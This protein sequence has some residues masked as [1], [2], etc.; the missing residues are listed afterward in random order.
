MDAHGIV[1]KQQTVVLNQSGVDRSM[2]VLHQ[3][4]EISLLGSYILNKT[5]HRIGGPSL[6]YI[7]IILGVLG[8]AGIRP[9]EHRPQEGCE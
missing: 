8:N 4:S 2:G 3:A 1:L 9:D 5:A 7:T 6:S